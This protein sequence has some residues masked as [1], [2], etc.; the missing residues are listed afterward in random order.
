MAATAFTWQHRALMA[1]TRS[2]TQAHA[3]T[4]HGT[5]KTGHA[6]NASLSHSLSALRLHS[7]TAGPTALLVCFIAEDAFQ[8]TH[9]RRLLRCWGCILCAA[10]GKGHSRAEGRGAGAQAANSERGH[11]KRSRGVSWCWRQPV[12][13]ALWQLGLVASSR[14]NLV[15]APVQPCLQPHTGGHAWSQQGWPWL[16]STSIGGGFSRH[17]QNPSSTWRRPHRSKHPQI[18][19]HRAPLPSTHSCTAESRH[20]CLAADGCK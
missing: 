5:Q 15:N 8:A 20:I 16:C 19:F 1:I 7:L 11:R 3:S 4:R 18:S 17:L 12:L 6:N 13:Q 10:S 9:H 2:T 14:P